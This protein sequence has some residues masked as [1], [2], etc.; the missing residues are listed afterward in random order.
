MEPVRR[1]VMLLVAGCAVACVTPV[2]YYDADHGDYHVWNRGEIVYYQ[3]WEVETH[4]E[5][6]DYDRRSA[7]DQRAYWNWRHS[8][9]DHDHH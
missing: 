1:A 8:H 5:H 6:V 4:H 7:D 3:Q 9:E 2:R